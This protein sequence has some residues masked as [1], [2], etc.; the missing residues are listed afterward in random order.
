MEVRYPTDRDLPIPNV[1]CSGLPMDAELQ[2]WRVLAS[3]DSLL[4]DALVE[5]H[6]VFSDANNLGKPDR[7]KST[8][9]KRI[10]SQ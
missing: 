2:Q 7:P 10:R 3:G 9:Q 8:T 5:L 6:G 1:A 4:A